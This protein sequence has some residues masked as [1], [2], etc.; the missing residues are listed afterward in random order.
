MRHVLMMAAAFALLAVAPA[1]HA[2]MIDNNGKCHDASGKLAKA[3][4]CKG[5][6]DPNGPYTRDAK[7]HCRNAKGVIAS[8]SKCSKG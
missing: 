7:G 4:V 8:K 3:E 6:A 5:V 1:S 2:Q